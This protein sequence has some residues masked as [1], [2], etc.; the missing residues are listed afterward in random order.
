[1]TSNSSEFV[2]LASY[3]QNQQAEKHN[4][5]FRLLNDVLEGKQNRTE[6]KKNLELSTTELKDKQLDDIRKLW[7]D[8]TYPTC[9]VSHMISIHNEYVNEQQDLENK[10]IADQAE[11][12]RSE[13]VLRPNLKVSAETLGIS[14]ARR[15]IKKLPA[16]HYVSSNGATY[17]IDPH[18]G[19][20]RKFPLLYQNPISSLC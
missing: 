7:S 4:R 20:K 8:V 14:M 9:D 15:P 12:I 16:N 6:L 19:K 2:L 1:M 17:G 3:L 13:T 18:S 10:R 5:Q 11:Y